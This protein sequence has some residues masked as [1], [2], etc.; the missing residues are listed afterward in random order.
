ML[1]LAYAGLD[2]WVQYQADNEGYAILIMVPLL[3]FISLLVV[4]QTVKRLHDTNL[5]GWWWLLLLVPVVGNLFGAGIPLV[6]GTA[7]P[8]RF[9][10]DPKKRRGYAPPTSNEA[11]AVL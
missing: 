6:D 5:A 11:T 9:G 1:L 8:N 10:P 7:G 2:Y 3:L 4:I